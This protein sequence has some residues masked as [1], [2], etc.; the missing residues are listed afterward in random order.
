M[1]E[2]TRFLVDLQEHFMEF[3]LAIQHTM[4]DLHP[5]E[6]TL[7]CIRLYGYMVENAVMRTACPHLVGMDI[8]EIDVINKTMQSLYPKLEQ[9]IV[10]Y[11]IPSAL[12]R[13][14]VDLSIPSQTIIRVFIREAQT[15]E[16]KLIDR[17]IDDLAEGVSYPRHIRHMI[18]QE[19]PNAISLKQRG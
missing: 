7:S 9:V 6:V 3:K 1:S 15:F 14:L 16:N 2:T 18:E 12:D 10:D 4:T 17:I 19:Y 8:H 11:E 13:A 5:R